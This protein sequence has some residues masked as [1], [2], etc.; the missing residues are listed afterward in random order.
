[1]I[2][3][4]DRNRIETGKPIKVFARTSLM[5]YSRTKYTHPNFTQDT[6]SISSLEK[7]IKPADHLAPYLARIGNPK[8]ISKAQAYLLREDCLNDFKQSEVNKANLIVRES[9]KLTEKLNELQTLLTQVYRF[10]P[11]KLHVRI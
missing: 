7:I 11:L 3:S 10:T 5:Y 8:Q 6:A 4:F 9:E 1:M 2:S